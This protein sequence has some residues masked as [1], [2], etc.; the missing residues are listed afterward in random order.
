MQPIEDDAA[1]AWEKATR[2]EALQIKTKTAV[3]LTGTNTY[4]MTNGAITAMTKLSNSMIA[5][6]TV[7]LKKQEENDDTSLKSW[8]RLPKL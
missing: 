3:D 7:A 8:R 1:L 4:G 2:E 5:Q 6:Q